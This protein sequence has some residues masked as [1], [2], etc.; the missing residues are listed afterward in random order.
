MSEPV[1][2]ISHFRVKEGST[3][4]L[5]AFVAQVST[6]MA[7]EKP[8]TLAYLSYVDDDGSNMTI[9]HVF[10]DAASMDRHFEGSEGRSKRAYELVEPQGWE[11]YGHASGPT[12]ESMRR[13]ASSAGV[14]LNLGPEYL[15]GFLRPK[16]A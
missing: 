5:R 16:P 8:Q 12:V 2:F 4:R 1:V 3:D 11:I 6:E 9:V 14:A 10:P 7:A 13:E 15:G